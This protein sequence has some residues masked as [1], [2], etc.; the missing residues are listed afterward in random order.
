MVVFKIALEM[1]KFLEFETHLNFIIEITLWNGNS[2]AVIFHLICWKLIILYGLI[3]FDLGDVHVCCG[4][5]PCLDFFFFTFIFSWTCIILT[6]VSFWG[7]EELIYGNIIPKVKLI[8]SFWYVSYEME[9]C[10]DY[11]Q[12]QQIRI[13]S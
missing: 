1:I 5:P 7:R 4:A 11:V 10:N 13:I 8:M 12:I 6:Q 2:I 9:L 3:F